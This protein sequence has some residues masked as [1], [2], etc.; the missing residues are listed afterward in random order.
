MLMTDNLQMISDRLAQSFNNVKPFEPVDLSKVK[1]G[2][3]NTQM[4][5]GDFTVTVSTLTND[6]KTKQNRNQATY[7]RV[8][9]IN[10]TT[11]YTF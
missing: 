2:M 9:T 5:I 8:V 6:S 1:G 11:D 7:F 4:Q 10:G 3:T